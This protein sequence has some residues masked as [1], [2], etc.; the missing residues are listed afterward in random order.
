MDHEHDIDL[1]SGVSAFEAKHFSRAMQL[2]SPH[3]QIGNAEAQY[4]LGIM[5]QNGLGTV[6]NSAL[7]FRWMQEA[8]QQNHGLAHHGLGFMYLEGNCVDRDDRKAADCFARGVEQGLE[9]SMIALAQLYEEGRGVE[10]DRHRA[11]VLY[12]QAGLAEPKIPSPE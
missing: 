2:L 3:A 10:R 4:R 1:A 7:A 11:Q 8:A 6:H 9:G 5:Y 12:Q